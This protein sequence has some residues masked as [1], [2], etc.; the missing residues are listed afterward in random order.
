MYYFQ[1]LD[2]EVLGDRYQEEQA[3]IRKMA[4]EAFLREANRP[5]WEYDN[6]Y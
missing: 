3:L 2:P 5:Q 6:G 1:P 4:E